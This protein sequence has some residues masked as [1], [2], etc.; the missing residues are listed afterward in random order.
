MPEK[1]IWLDGDIGPASD[2]KLDPTDE[3][4]LYGRGLFET[5]RTFNCRPWLWDRHIQRALQTARIIGI[6]LESSDLPTAGEVMEY[7]QAVGGDDIVVRLQIGAISTSGHKRIWMISRPL[8]VLMPS[9]KLTVSSYRVSRADQL[10]GLKT[11]NYLLRQLAYEEATSHGS[12]DSFRD[13]ILLSTE[14]EVLET[15][16]SNIFARFGDEWITPPDEGGLLAGTVRSVLLEEA[17]SLSIV[18]RSFTLNDLLRCDEAV[19]TNSVRGIVPVASVDEYTF[20]STDSIRPL[21]DLL[22]THR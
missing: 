14:G 16:H 1:L 3:A 4:V 19:V 6:K 21:I 22:E 8:P 12:T 20:P 5:T 18:E 10:A 7:V 13:A 2:F 17:G 11:T 15:A 9:I